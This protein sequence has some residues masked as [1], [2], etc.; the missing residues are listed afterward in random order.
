L[1]A[2][3]RRELQNARKRLGAIEQLQVGRTD[4]EL[5]VALHT[6]L[7]MWAQRAYDKTLWG[8]GFKAHKHWKRYV[9]AK[10]AE[11]PANAIKM[12]D[13]LVALIERYHSHVVVNLGRLAQ[14]TVQFCR[15]GL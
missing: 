6:E 15:P 3:L 9:G 8:D 5:Y 2:E 10:K 7:K 1:V 14:S 13:G 11:Q 12:R 4:A